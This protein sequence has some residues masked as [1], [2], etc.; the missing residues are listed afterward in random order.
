MNV[1]ACALFDFRFHAVYLNGVWCTVYT[2][3]VQQEEKNNESNPHEFAK[4]NET[5]SFVCAFVAFI[6]Y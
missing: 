3:E 1:C 4:K 2:L 5:H 6:L